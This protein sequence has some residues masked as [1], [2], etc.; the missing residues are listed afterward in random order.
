[1]RYDALS[2]VS[3]MKTAS[4]KS[5]DIDLYVY[6]TTINH[7]LRSFPELIMVSGLLILNC[8]RHDDEAGERCIDW[9]V[10]ILVLTCMILSIILKY[11]DNKKIYKSNEIIITP[12]KYTVFRESMWLVLL[13]LNAFNAW[14]G[15]YLRDYFDHQNSMSKITL[16]N[17]IS[18][19]DIGVE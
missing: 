12:K 1:M 2:T 4:N 3:I 17:T 9:L 15:K 5:P 14:T 8:F 18:M 7:V 11:L 10:I 6:R 16:S 19:P 13:S